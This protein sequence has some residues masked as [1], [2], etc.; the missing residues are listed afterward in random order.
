MLV[1]VFL[2]LLVNSHA[3][4]VPVAYGVGL[5]SS[6]EYINQDSLVL[7][8]ARAQILDMEEK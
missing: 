2:A 6:V 8:L 3:I 1:I 4:S 7:N 5:V